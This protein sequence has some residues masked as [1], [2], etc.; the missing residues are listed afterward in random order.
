M[1]MQLEGI[2]NAGK[3]RLEKSQIQI[4]GKIKVEV[5]SEQMPSERVSAI[6]A[7]LKNDRSN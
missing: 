3:L 1:Q 2:Q 7:V 4:K 6:R 5:F